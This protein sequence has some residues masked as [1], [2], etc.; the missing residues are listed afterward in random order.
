M[1][2]Q[3]AVRG[4][5]T[6]PRLVFRACATFY[7]ASLDPTG[8]RRLV[9]VLAER[10]VRADVVGRRDLGIVSIAFGL[11]AETADEALHDAEELLHA[12]SGDAPHALGVVR[13]A[14]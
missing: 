12:A 5:G 2:P 13:M 6:Q 8:C 11:G 9:A 4:Q 14:R 1:A 7:A 10:G 3:P